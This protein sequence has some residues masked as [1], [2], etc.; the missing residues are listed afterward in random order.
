MRRLTDEEFKR[1][2]WEK[3]GDFIISTEPF[4]GMHAKIGFQCHKGHAFPTTPTGILNDRVKTG[5]PH[6]GKASARESLRNTVEEL[7]SQVE[8]KHGDNFTLVGP[9]LG[10]KKKT[11]W[12][13]RK[14]HKLFSSPENILGL[15]GCKRCAGKVNT[16]EEYLEELQVRFNGKIWP[17]EP[18]L[19]SRIKIRH[20]CINGHEYNQ[21][22]NQV[23]G[24][25]T[26]SCSDC[27]NNKRR[28][29]EEY[30]K[31]IAAIHHG[32]VFRIGNYDGSN[33]RLLHGCGICGREFPATPGSV[34]YAK[35]GCK[36]CAE[37]GFKMTKSAILY[38]L[39]IIEKATGNHYYKIGITNRTSEFRIAQMLRSCVTIDVISVQA[40]TTGK[41]A[42]KAEQRILN[43]FSQHRITNFKL[44]KNGNSEVFSK[45]IAEY[46]SCYFTS[47]T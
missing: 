10:R 16:H 26:G 15:P 45:D 24:S 39:K 7:M 20:A 43:D 40:F 33:K 42:F 4:T 32:L 14:G 12:K 1:R 34:K 8:A 5:C 29:N 31:E 22:P 18:Y 6:C 35:T 19:A 38:Y 41:G 30:D 11:D 17:L 9:Y 3:Y 47:T 23:M 37:Y 28:T 44:L 21:C 27:T 25:K 2:L 46:L 13:C 36:E